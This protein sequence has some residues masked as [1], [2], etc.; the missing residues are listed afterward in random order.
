MASGSNDLWNAEV[1]SGDAPPVEKSGWRSGLA[2]LRW[3]GGTAARAKRILLGQNINDGVLF[4]IALYIV[5]LS[6]AVMY[7][8]PV[9]YMLATS[10]KSMS[11]LL[12]QSVTYIPRQFDLQ[13]YD[14]AWI[15]LDYL[16]ALWQTTYMSLS[17]AILQVLSCGLTG[18]AFARLRI[19][20][21]NVLFF[22]VLL[23]FLIP[24]QVLVIP[25]YVTY[26]KLNWTKTALP[27]IIPAIFAAGLKASLFII[28]YRQFFATLPK[29]LEE[30]AKIDGAGPFRTFVKVMLPLARPAILIVFLFSIVWHWNDY[31]EPSVYLQASQ[32]NDFVPLALRLDR[33]QEALNLHKSLATGQNVHLIFDMNEPLK[34]AGAILIIGP[35][36]FLYMFAQ[37]YFVQGIERSGIVE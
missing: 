5:L 30:S 18:Y 28:I 12:D 7:I 36:L 32:A 21:K 29:E 2:G 15:G 31:F 34:M 13:G 37:R 3:N 33:M 4:K 24:P 26:A 20:F 22:I 23:T 8:Q 17:A 6:I 35:M 10:F 14:D 16:K 1:R 27:F 25:L 19:P 9:L 11:D